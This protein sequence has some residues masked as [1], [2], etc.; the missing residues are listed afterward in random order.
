MGKD[1]S[2]EE[3]FLI[4]Q[5]YF[6]MLKMELSGQHINKSLHRKLLR[7]LLDN[8]SE[9]SIEFKHRNIS[10]ILEMLG[11]PFIFGYKPLYNYQRSL[12]G[13]ILQFLRLNP[14]IEGVMMKSK[15]ENPMTS[16]TVDFQHIMVSPPSISTIQKKKDQPIKDPT[17]KN[18]I[19]QEERNIELGVKGEEL[20]YEYEKFKLNSEGKFSLAKEIIW[21]SKDKGDGF[22][23]DILSKN[24]DGSDKYIEVKTTV[25]GKET[26]FFFTSNE[27]N[28]SIKN[29]SYFHLYRL[30]NFNISPK[31]FILKGSYP[32]FCNIKPSIYNGYF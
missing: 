25:L 1:W 8:R 9:A 28:F 32:E 26:P 10:A 7:P 18:Y 29:K 11:I 12:I 30:F 24:L 16:N 14:D 4:V 2:T 21:I 3:V 20:V 27:L 19:E 23:F 5:D 6:S 17:T 22:G 13:N 15:V 31:L